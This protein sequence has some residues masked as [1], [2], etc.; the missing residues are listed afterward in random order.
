MTPLSPPFPTSVFYSPP[1]QL[2]SSASLSSPSDLS[3]LSRSLKQLTS[4]SILKAKATIWNWWRSKKSSPH[5]SPSLKHL[6]LLLRLLRSP[7]NSLAQV[8]SAS[9]EWLHSHFPPDK[10]PAFPIMHDRYFLIP[11][12]L[13]S[14]LCHQYQSSPYTNLPVHLEFLNFPLLPHILGKSVVSPPLRSH[15]IQELF[16]PHQVKSVLL[17]PNSIPPCRLPA[18][19]GL[20]FPPLS[21]HTGPLSFI[22]MTHS[23]VPFPPCPAP[24]THDFF[25][26]TITSPDSAPGAD[27]LPYAAWRV[28]HTTSSIC[29][30]QHFQD[31]IFRKVRPP[32]QS[33]VFIPKADQG[34]YADNYR[35]LGLPNT[36]DRIID[37]AAYCP[38]L[39]NSYELSTSRSGTPQ[40]V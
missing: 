18:L 14:K 37:R 4:P 1:S 24:S 11:V 33:L 17:P 3:S 10:A 12:Y 9:W 36:C 20:T 6:H 15:N 16:A 19:F 5:I 32:Q 28:C 40:Y 21:H 27:G 8:P 23:S 29:L 2:H 31:I 7:S 25:H 13:L 22:S 39:P 35:P 34:E 26:A 30:N 38:F